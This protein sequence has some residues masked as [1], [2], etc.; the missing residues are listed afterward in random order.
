MFGFK[1]IE[2]NELI[3]KC[4][5]SAVIHR[6]ISH[7]YIF[8]GP[9]GI[10]KK[11][12]ANSFAKTVMCGRPKRS[13]QGVDACGEC[14]SCVT[15]ES[16]NHPDMRYVRLDGKKSLG[17][18]E[19]RQKV[20][21]DMT[22]MPNQSPYKIFIIEDADAMTPAAQNALL[23]TIEEPESYGLFLLL[24]Q[25]AA[26]F[27]PTV[28]SRCV[29]FK[30]K[31]LTNEQA[32]RH[33]VRRAG[34]GRRDAEALS[35]YAQGNIGRALSL[36]DDESFI[37]MRRHVFEILDK[38]SYVG[39]FDLF[40]MAKN[41]EPYKERGQEVLDIMYYWYHDVL[42]YLAAGR[43]F[44][45]QSDRMDAIRQAA[46]ALPDISAALNRLRAVW[47]AKRRLMNYA[48]FQLTIEVMLFALTE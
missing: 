12:M 30:L 15:F 20:T 31:P 2:G 9:A 21:L 32:A 36:A 1:E 43:R 27:L 13:D 17:V 14:V 28:L 18:D 35:V 19:I 47:D 23:K 26:K 4:L 46:E 6:R 24:A 34:I 42:V 10:G 41:L 39:L 29:T 45:T 5:Q 22:V 48:N 7:A 16:G 11:L 25:N 3:V 38:L 40:G 44:V 33:L 37:A 8:A